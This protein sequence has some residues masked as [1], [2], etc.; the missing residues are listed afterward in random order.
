MKAAVTA[1]AVNC[2]VAREVYFHRN[3]HINRLF[4]VLLSKGLEAVRMWVG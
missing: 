1:T 4:D 3:V 2:S